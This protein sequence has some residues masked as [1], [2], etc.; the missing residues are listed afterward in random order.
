MLLQV[1]TIIVPIFF[2]LLRGFAA[3][4]A[5]AFDGDRVAGINELV[6]DFALPASLFVGTVGVARTQLL[7]QGP[8]LLVLLV[9][10]VGLYVVVALL[11]RLLFRHTLANSALQAIAVTFAAG[12][13]F[14]P[15]LLSGL[16]G[17]NSAVAI[18]LWP[19]LWCSSAC[20]C[21][22]WSAPR[23]ASSV[24]RPLA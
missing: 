10:V 23:S 18:S 3:G 9:S 6:L 4:R 12:P 15:A 2:V 19:S 22:H 17:T 16:Y 1:L 11:G 5:R 8:L 13:F 7:Q 21:P 24:A 14:G 20:A